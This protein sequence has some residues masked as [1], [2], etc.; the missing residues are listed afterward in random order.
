MEVRRYTDPRAFRGAAEPWLE[1]SE[2]AHNLLL[3]LLPMLET[4]DHGFE[5]PIY[6]ATIESSGQI[7]GCAFRTPP[8][9]L[10][11]TRMPLEAIPSLIQ[12]LRDTGTEVPG[13]IGPP[14]PTEACAVAWARAHGR[15]ARTGMHQRIHAL[16][17]L[18]PPAPLASGSRRT[19][20]LDELPLLAS[21]SGAFT[22]EAHALIAEPVGLT[23]QLIAAGG[24]H[25]WDHLGPRAMAA[26]MGRT[27]RGVRIGLV[28]TPP[29]ERRHGYATALVASLSRHQ[30]QLGC[31]F[32]FLYTDTSN[33][34][35]NAI[36]ARLGYRPVCESVE[37]HID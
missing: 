36:Y 21:W 29:A 19:A 7:C 25:V 8:Y 6:L 16:E 30:L 34:T 28:Y 17:T 12:N 37:F 3:G 22:A 13:V 26:V 31:R 11:V 23:R 24:L 18:S 1:R 33:P 32:C 27:R 14:E 20:H 2:A 4:S 15:K 35:S 10:G 9:H 5:G